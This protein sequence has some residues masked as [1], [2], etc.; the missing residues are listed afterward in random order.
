MSIN[1]TLKNDAHSGPTPECTSCSHSQR[2][3]KYL[4]EQVCS[5]DLEHSLRGAILLF[6]EVL[7]ITEDEE[8]FA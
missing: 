1:N 8:I 2:E 6:G 7:S 5:K 3:Q 4:S